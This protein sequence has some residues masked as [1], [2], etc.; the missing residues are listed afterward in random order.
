M[1]FSAQGGFKSFCSKKSDISHTLSAVWGYS[2]FTAF[3]CVTIQFGVVLLGWCLLLWFGDTFGSP[4]FLGF[5]VLTSPH[6]KQRSNVAQYHF[7]EHALRTCWWSRYRAPSHPLSSPGYFWSGTWSSQVIQNFYISFLQLC[8][9]KPGALTRE[10]LH[11]A[12]AYQWMPDCRAC[13]SPSSAPP[14]PALEWQP[15]GYKTA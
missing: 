12:H 14:P 8:G 10:S 7:A 1:Q 4:L 6:G 5:G 9:V 11:E 2:R 15:W 3:C 13:P